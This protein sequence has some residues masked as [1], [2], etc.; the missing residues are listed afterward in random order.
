MDPMHAFYK[1]GVALVIG[2][3]I[4][5][6]RE[7]AFD[8]GDNRQDLGESLFAGARTFALIALFGCTA[9]FVGDISGSR[10]AAIILMLMMGVMI[11]VAYAF[12]ARRGQLGMTTGV[13][14]L[15]TVLIGAVCY[16]D[17]L[18]IATALGVIT[19]TLLTLKVQTQWLARNISREDL[20]A[21]LKFAIMTVI[22]LPVLPQTGYGPPPFNI[23]VPYQ[24]WLMVVFISGI[25]FFGYLLMKFVGPSKGVG[26]TGLLGGMVSST[27]VT[28]NF[29]Q[30]SN[31]TQHLSRAFAL[32]I[33]AAWGVMFLRIMII[34][35]VLNI[36]L[37]RLVWIPMT[38]AFFVSLLFCVY[39][40]MS[41]KTEPPE[42]ANDF[43]N[44]FKLIPAITFGLLYAIILLAA[45][46]A[47][48]YFGD[49]GVYLSSIISGLVDVDAITVSMSQLSSSQNGL[50]STAASRSIVFAAASNTFIKG[51]I[52]LFTA[53]GS[54][55]RI[56]LP[57]MILIIVTA[58]GVTLLI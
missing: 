54:L 58:I 44:P 29:A 2:L 39:L 50:G 53:S 33:M 30:R 35:G 9:A 31:D 56:V 40:G 45:N 17:F 22:V 5:L 1:F 6:Q 8:K 19:M 27:A 15:M 3:L 21:T 36:S 38:L 46:T 32:G 48:I 10:W 55:R 52:V 26:F 7:Y 4:G 42:E 20:Y 11:M 28:L 37:L 13:A 43:K 47:R 25:S 57:G 34:V 41:Q 24:I 12:E 49:S 18:V 23:L 16:W 14:A 51:C